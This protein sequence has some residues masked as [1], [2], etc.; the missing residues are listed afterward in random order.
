MSAR[1]A[2]GGLNSRGCP[3]S[4]APRLWTLWQ[5]RLILQDCAGLLCQPWLC[6]P[7]LCRRPAGSLQPRL[8]VDAVWVAKQRATQQTTVLSCGASCWQL[9]GVRVSPPSCSAHESS[10]SVSCNTG[11]RGTAGEE[12]WGDACC[13]CLVTCLQ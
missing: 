8:V 11:C 9:G 6:L 7:E 5:R 1:S 3:C 12:L 2:L 10:L 4:P 13:G